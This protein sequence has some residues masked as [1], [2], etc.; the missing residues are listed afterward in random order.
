MLGKTADWTKENQ[1]MKQYILNIKQFI[2]G[3]VSGGLLLGS[4]AAYVTN[5]RIVGGSGYLM[6]YEVTVNGRSICD[7]PY[8]WIGTKEIECD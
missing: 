8:V 6:G 2:I 3:F 7:D 4:A 5:P 1:S